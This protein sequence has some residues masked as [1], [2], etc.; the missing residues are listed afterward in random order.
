MGHPEPPLRWLWMYL[1]CKAT[2]QTSLWC[3]FGHEPVTVP[4]LPAYTST[5]M[6]SLP[7]SLFISQTPWVHF[8]QWAQ[9][10][11]SLA[12]LM[13][14]SQGWPTAP[15]DSFIQLITHTPHIIDPASHPPM[16]LDVLC[17]SLSRHLVFT[18]HWPSGG[19]R[20]WCGCRMNRFAD[21][22]IYRA[23]CRLQH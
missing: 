4:A 1:Q 15:T 5:S 21:L 12:N 14:A 18:L 19:P 6:L 22:Y 13:T 23:N 16:A 9:P 10:K 3:Q 17:S 11:I 8:C 20:R 2:L 7:L